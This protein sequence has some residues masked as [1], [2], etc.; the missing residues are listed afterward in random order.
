[1]TDAVSKAMALGENLKRFRCA[2]GLTQ[3]QLAQIIGYT[4]KSVSKWENGKGMPSAETVLRLSLL[5]GISPE[6][7]MLRETGEKYFLGIDGGGTKTAFKLTDGNGNTVRELCLGPGNPNDVGMDKTQALLRKG[8]GEVC[9]GIALS[10]VTMF[11]GLSGGGLTGDNAG[12][13][14]RFF[15]EFGFFAFENGS[16]IENLAGLADSQRCVL[17]IMGTGFAV[18][19]VDGEKR[20]RIAGWGQLFDDGGS[21]Y[22]LGRD[23]ITAA[24]CECDGS[25]EKTLISGLL[26]ERLGKTAE[27][28]LAQ[29]YREGKKYIASFADTVFEAA[30]AG[31]RV[32]LDILERNMSFAAE[33]INTA[34]GCF[35][36]GAEGE[37][38]PVF[39]SGGL[40]ARAEVLF[41]MIGR[42][43]E[44]C[45]LVKLEKAPVEGALNRARRI[46]EEKA[47][48][49]GKTE[50]AEQC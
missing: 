43:T 1:M 3:K 28:A 40:C 15:R 37:V 11:A 26:T 18:F 23:G 35:G 46:F 45:R 5:F 39:V 9:A 12:V 30:E 47:K 19:A 34:L 27:E 24:L 32:A 41:E 8:I 22:T 21:A 4:E 20:K 48:I 14:R 29:F 6:R 38:I 33:K 10:D 49:S 31:D 17:V 50:G 13:L 7:L 42:H 16:D 2:R 36:E 44:G 25:G